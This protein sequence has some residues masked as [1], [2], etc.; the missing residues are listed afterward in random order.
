[1]FL[2]LFYTSYAK[3]ETKIIEVSDNTTT[4]LQQV[5]TGTQTICREAENEGL[6]GNQILGS[7]IG[8]VIGSKIGKGE[9][10][11]IAIGTGAVIGSQ[12]GK[13]QDKKLKSYCYEETTYV[14]QQV[15]QYVNST[16]VFQHEGKVYYINFVK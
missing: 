13:N 11:D 16:L 12:I 6:T 15:E 7:I 4:V 5:P 8:G 1:M 10:R 3:A 2:A 14:T 9:G